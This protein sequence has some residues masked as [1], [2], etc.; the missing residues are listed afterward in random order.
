M[1]K[2]RFLKA[3][4]LL[5]IATLAAGTISC[6]KCRECTATDYDGYIVAYEERCA[7]GPNAKKVV[8]DFEEDFRST[9]SSY[10]VTCQDNK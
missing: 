5:L 7:A 6:K 1:I 4:L 3:L 10:Y 9:W 8:N 2:N